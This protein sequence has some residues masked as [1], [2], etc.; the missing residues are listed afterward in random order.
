MRKCYFTHYE[1]T[2]AQ[3]EQYVRDS[4]KLSLE[5]LVRGWDTDRQK[6]VERSAKHYLA[7]LK[8]IED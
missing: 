3:A 4:E 1:E 8:E 2:L 5:A 7:W 6:E